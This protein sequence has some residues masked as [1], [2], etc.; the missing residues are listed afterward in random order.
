MAKQAYIFEVSE[1]NFDTLVLDNSNKMPVVV[2][3]MSVS[4]EP[5]IILEHRMSE[6]ANEFAEQ[7]VFAKVDIYEQPDLA[8]AFKVE[9][10]PTTIVFEKGDIQHTELGQMTKDEIAVMLRN[11]GVYRASDDM[12]LQAREK[13]INGDTTAAVELLTQAIQTDPSNS[14]VVMDMVQILLDVD[15]LDTA[16][17]IFN[18]LPDAEK[19][20][21]TGRALVGQITFKQLAAKAPGLV[22]LNER[23]EADENDAEARFNLAIWM[24][25]NFQ[26]Q[27]AMEHL[28]TLQKQQP[29]YQN[30]APKE[31]IITLSNMLAPNEPTLAQR[32][33]QQL[34][35]LLN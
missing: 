25:A 8:K 15:Q 20:S 11:V 30:G 17:E 14:R 18:K 3:F 6:M 26:Y 21:E 31:M 5:C 27:E 13:H 28:F 34:N 1:N 23:L 7:F 12:R 22:A 32:Y 29:D 4:S 24:V 19:Q 9:Q 35:S 10:L 33:R 16:M 2:E